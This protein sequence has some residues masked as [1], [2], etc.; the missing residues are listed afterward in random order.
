MSTK[1]KP[2]FHLNGSSPETLSD[3][4]WKVRA[5]LGVAEKLL[6]ETAPNARDFYIQ[7]DS[8]AKRRG[9]VNEFRERME[10][11]Q[12]LKDDMV[13]LAEHAQVTIDEREA[14]RNR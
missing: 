2:T 13:A 4:Y 3:E 8:D 11:I 6:V 9:A 12:K 14:R 1:F 10:M 7:K 5:A